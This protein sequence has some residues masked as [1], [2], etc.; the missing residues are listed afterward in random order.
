MDDLEVH[1]ELRVL[2]LEGMVAMGRGD[3]DLLHPVVDKGLDVLPGQLLEEVLIAG[4]ADA[5]AAAVLLLSPG[6]RSRRPP[7]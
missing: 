1:L 7:S 2:V 4:L 5:L 3:K 6:S